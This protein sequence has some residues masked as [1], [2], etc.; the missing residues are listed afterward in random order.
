MLFTACQKEDYT[1]NNTKE[2]EGVVVYIFSRE[3]CQHCTQALQFLQEPEDS[4][5]AVRAGKRQH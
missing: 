4:F 2:E 1:V 5:S 3:G